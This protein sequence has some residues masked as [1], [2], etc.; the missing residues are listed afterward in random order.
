MAT[1]TAPKQQIVALVEQTHKSD[2]RRVPDE[3]HVC[4]PESSA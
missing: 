1:A 2:V 3:L 4:E